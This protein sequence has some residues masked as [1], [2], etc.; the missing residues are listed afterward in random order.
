MPRVTIRFEDALYGRIAGSAEAAGTSLAE[1]IRDV[2]D[3]FEGLD[4]AG[5]HNRFDEL[6]ATNI[7]VFAVLT[8]ALKA[9]RPDLLQQGMEDARRLMIERALLDPEQGRS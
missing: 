9:V 6:H 3:R 5:Y 2:L 4:A 7:Q 8:A 1:Y